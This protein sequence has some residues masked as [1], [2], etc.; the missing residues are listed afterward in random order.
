MSHNQ[1]A[2][3]GSRI[4]VI[5]LDAAGV[6]QTRYSAEILPT[7]I[8]NG[9]V[10]RARWTRRPVVT[11]YTTFA[12]GDYL[13]EFFYRDR[14]YNIFALYDGQ[15]ERLKGWYCNVTRPTQITSSAIVWTDL[16]LDVWVSPTGQMTLLD[17][18]EFEALGLK[19]ADIQ[20]SHDAVA[21][22]QA[23]AKDNRLPK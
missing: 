1:K 3:S 14:W 23:L 9:I 12:L 20:Q 18:D 15:T 5:K 7:P 2:D 4:A 13:H 8:P 22:L 16:A 21:Q 6:E 17:E 10:V 19:S 11:H